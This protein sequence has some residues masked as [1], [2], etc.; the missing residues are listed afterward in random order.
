MR[1]KDKVALI[2]GGSRGIG[3]ATADRFLQEGAVVILT[4]SSQG[5]ADRAV[6]RLKEK[7]PGG[8]VAGISPDLSSLESVRAAFQ[9]ATSVYGCIDILVNNA[10]VSESTPFME[11][12]EETFDKVM[13]LN[14][15]GGVQR[16]PRRR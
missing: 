11:Y 5:S 7:H 13:D 6:A 16:H 9:E 10:G 15:K 14:I 1:L 4:A 8:T 3:F 12:T 2:T